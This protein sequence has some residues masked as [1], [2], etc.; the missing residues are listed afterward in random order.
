MKLMRINPSPAAGGAGVAARGR[1]N[2][3]RL[4]LAATAIVL[5]SGA[6]AALGE[7]TAVQ[8][9]WHVGPTPDVRAICHAGDS[10]WV[11]SSAGLF[12]LDIRDPSRR[13]HIGAGR[14]L[15]SNSVRAIAS[16]G[17]SV[18]VATDAGVTVFF[19][20][21]ATLHS[22]RASHTSG[23]IPL[24]FVQHIAFGNNGEVLLSTRR[25]GV[26]V[27]TRSGGFAITRRDSLIGDDVFGILERDGRPRLYACA[28]GLCAQVND[29]TMVSFQA[30]AGVPRGEV[31][32]VVGDPRTAYVRVARRGI[33]QFDGQ[34]A[35]ALTAPNGVS[36]LD[37]T[38]IALGADH[39]LWVA[40]PGFVIVRRDGKWQRVQTPPDLAP[41][42]SAIVADGAGAFVGSDDGVVLALNRGTDFRASLG[43]G[44]PA[45]AVASLRP[46]GRGSAW[47]VSGGRVISAHAGSRGLTVEKS[48]L[49]AA[50]VD[51]SPTGGLVV[52][53]RW[54][55]SRKNE[56]GWVDLTPDIDETD[57]AFTSVFAGGGNIIWVGA[58][59]GALYR[60]D[61]EIWVRYA[62]PRADAMALRDARAF[63]ADDWA[64]LGPAPMRSV[65]GRWC[66]FA[67]WD[68]S[69]VVVDVAV[70]PAGE[71]FAATKDRL[72]RYDAKRDAW[73]PANDG[74]MSL[75]HAAG[76]PPSMITSI[77]FDPA[78]RLFIGATDGFGCYAGG[79]V[80]WWNVTDGIGGERVN[81]LATDTAS[82]WVGYGEDGLSVIPLA[83][84]R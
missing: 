3:T 38:S 7:E 68:S 39:A 56:T 6:V 10:L 66:P 23:K 45:P 67:G 72:L 26:G 12:V 70:S 28:A 17:D 58:G 50:A 73:Q 60:F 61:G 83:S 74:S 4:V 77:S 53:G 32:Q 2:R 82:L 78:G 37:A 16:R 8:D 64:L 11:G 9:A 1:K 57:P 34:R 55:V 43:E 40:G 35:T 52:A 22:A 19:R 18:W 5:A 54:T 62:R 81:D 48:P 84:L 65:S 79:Q 21:Q 71:W 24:R 14:E 51:F 49:D 29:T 25:G 41:S 33:Y 13:A 59:S 27:L 46:D 76:D 69:G 80:R 20:G 15:A 30:G 47:F 44:L 75:P 31:R 63:P 36:F 42:W